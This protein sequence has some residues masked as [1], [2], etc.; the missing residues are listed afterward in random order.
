MSL[1]YPNEL[2]LAFE[3][4]LLFHLVSYLL[5]YFQY[6]FGVWTTLPPSVLFMLNS[7]L[8]F[9]S[10]VEQKVCGLHAKVHALQGRSHSYSILQA[11]SMEWELPFF[12]FYLGITS[13]DSMNPAQ[14]R[15]HSPVQRILNDCN[16][17]E[18]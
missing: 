10:Q 3:R 8:W 1:Q 2:I 7:S 9:L 5:L 17:Q 14:L 15:S 18:H 12:S 11:Y 13:L 16:N 6:V 4:D